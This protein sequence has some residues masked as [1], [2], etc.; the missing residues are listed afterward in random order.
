MIQRLGFKGFSLIELLVVIAILSV[1]LAIAIP[2]FISV[3]KI[4]SVKSEARLLKDVLARARM[5]AVRRNQSLTVT[6]DT[7][8]NRCTVS[9]TGGA[10]ISTVNFRRTQLSTA[11][12]PPQIVWDTK[13]MTNDFCT[14]NVTGQA[15]T[16]SVFVSA[17]GNIRI[18]R[19]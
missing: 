16:Y 2:N 4:K 10:V 5:D 18:T 8:N 7:A 14:I 17:A 6:I 1:G 3:G 11:L 9:V 13:G 19:S 12:N 15:V